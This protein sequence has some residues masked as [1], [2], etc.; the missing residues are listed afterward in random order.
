SPIGEELEWAR[1]ALGVQ[2]LYKDYGDLLADK[3]VDAVFIVTPH[4]LHPQQIIEALRAGKHVFCEKPLSMV[5]EECL[6]VEA[7]SAKHPNLKVM[8]GFVRRFDASY[9][10]AYNRIA[11]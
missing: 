11:A 5:L 10:G 8:I 6:A 2:S 1:T 7:E 4:T 9:E 3:S